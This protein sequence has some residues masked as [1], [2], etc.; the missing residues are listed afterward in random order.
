[1]TSKHVALAGLAVLWTGYLLTFND[2]TFRSET[3]LPPWVVI[4]GGSLL[5]VAHPVVF[6]PATRRW[7]T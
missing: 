7:R 1:M 6:W 2:L 4:A 3:V 5:V